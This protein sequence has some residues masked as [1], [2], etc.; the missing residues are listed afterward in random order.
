MRGAS[1]VDSRDI[2]RSR[3]RSRGHSLPN[4]NG[5]NQLRSSSRDKNDM[6]AMTKSHTEIP[7]SKTEIVNEINGKVE[8]T[9]KEV[10]MENPE[11]T[12]ETKKEPE[13]GPEPEKAPETEKGPEPEEK[14]NIPEQKNE[15]QQEQPASKEE[16]APEAKGPEAAENK[17]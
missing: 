5:G 16:K 6:T 3:S 13:K 7:Q 1:E 14:K 9:A 10:V 11:A 15:V 12:V 17:Q 2:R 4:V 8:E